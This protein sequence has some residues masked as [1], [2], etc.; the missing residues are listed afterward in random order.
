MALGDGLSARLAELEARFP[1]MRGRLAA[2]A[3]GATLRAVEEAVS[4][5]PSNTFGDGEQRDVNMISGEMAEH[6]ETDSSVTPVGDDFV[7]VLANNQEYASYVN[8]GYRVKKRFVPGLYIDPDTGLLSY[9]LDENR[10]RIRNDVPVGLMVG[11]RTTYVKGLHI[12]D[13][14]IDKYDETVRSELEKL[15]R[16]MEQ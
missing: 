12:T 6:W 1:D 8:E 15:M 16:E 7:T 14:A 3:E 2:I 13:K 5:T 9:N 10:Q 4:L 11:T